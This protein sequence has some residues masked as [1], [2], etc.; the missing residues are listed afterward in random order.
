MIRQNLLRLII[1]SVGTLG[2]SHAALVPL[3]ESYEL[4][5][6]QVT[7]PAHSAGQVVIRECAACSP[8]LMPVSSS[9]SYYLEPQRRVTLRELQDVADS[10]R[11][12]QSVGVYVFYTP[13][14]GV[15]TRI[16]LGVAG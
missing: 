5:L 10:L 14:T 13:E 7:L 16:V 3:E 2:A 15:V 9:T 8:K 12:K 6:D 4:G 11:K 1:V